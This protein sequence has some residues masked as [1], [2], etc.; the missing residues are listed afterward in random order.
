MQSRHRLIK[1]GALA[2]VVAV[3]VQVAGQEAHLRYRWNKG[4]ALRYKVTTDSTVTMSGVPGMGDMTVGNTMT[5]VQ[6]MTTD[7]VTAD[8][9]AT[10]SSKIES[11]RMDMN[12]PMGT[13]TYDSANAAAASDPMIAP[14]AQM[15]GALIGETVTVVLGPDGAVKSVTGATKLAEKLK[16][17]MPPGADAMGGLAGLDAMMSDEAMRATYG[18]NFASLP[19]K[20]VKPGDTW[21][22]EVKMPNPVGEMS[23]AQTFTVKD[24]MLMNGRPMTRILL[25]LDVK[26]APGGMMGP[27]SVQA[28]P[29]TGD[30]E[31]LFD[32][33]R[34]RLQKT[35]IHLTLP[36]QMSM[37]APDGTT[38][39]ISGQTKTTTT[40]EL[41]E[42]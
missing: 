9:T 17:N 40:V 10:V 20:P 3:G 38:I 22:S 34:G 13:M 15:M 6:V 21:K 35:V 7:D 36:M 18:Q 23:M 26:V 8:G 32:H 19:A 30:G 12:T 37:A 1:W 5:Q 33:T 25:G 42:R 4:E 39:N 28:G 14:I 31:T 24:I 29:G 2:I 11:V 16:Q 41:V 27:M